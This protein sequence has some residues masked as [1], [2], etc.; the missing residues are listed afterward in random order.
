[1]HLKFQTKL[2]L[3]ILFL[4]LLTSGWLT[5]QN[6][7]EVEKMFKQEMKEEGFLLAR[8]VEN[9]IANSKVFE[10]QVDQLMAER[11]L[12]ASEAVNLLPIETMTNEQL[13][14]LAPKLNISGGIFVIGPDRKIAYSDVVDYVGWEYPAGH[15]MDP[16]F[17]GTSRTYM[18][19]IRGDL[20]SGEMVKYGGIALSTPGYSVQIGVEATVI[21]DIKRKFSPDVLLKQL[22][23]RD[24]VVYAMMINSDGI[25]IAGTEEMKKEE[26][27]DDAVTIDA[28]KNEKEGAAESINSDT[29]ARIY[30][31]QIPY[32]EDG[33]HKGSIAVGISLDRMEKTLNA[34]LIKSLI[35]TSITCIVAVLIGIFV[36]RHLVSPLKKLSSQLNDIAQGDFTI[37]Q[38]SRLLE[39]KD[40]LGLIANAVQKMRIELSQLIMNLKND[41]HSLEDGADLL[42]NIMSE[43]SRAIEENA[44]AVEALAISA[45]DQASESEKVLL[46]AE[47]LG[48][49]VDQGKKN[50][51]EANNRVGIVNNLS[52]NGESIITELA[53][54]TKKSIGRTDAV[55]N[56]I[57]NV[58]KTVRNMREFTGRIRSI[59]EQTNLLAL[60]ASIEAARAGEAGRGFSVVADEIRKLAE[61]TNQ[62][63]EQVEVI[64]AEITDQ[65]NAA[66]EDIEA[67]SHVTTQQRETL[68]QTLDIFERIQVSIIELVHSMNQVVDVTNAV[69]VSKDTILSAVNVLTDLTENL[70]ATC[71]Q[72]SASTEEQTAA[73]NEVNQLTDTNRSLASDLT[74]RVRR[75]KTIDS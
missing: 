34:H 41:A 17:D 16:I 1:M 61:E 54:V 14:E 26:A 19:E 75:F 27:Y 8:S 7:N 53:E 12:Q 67:I 36:I 40:E 69:G 74:E 62:T 25:A 64:I 35:A 56:G 3:M 51:E 13:I 65:T 5:Y 44:K 30:D 55:S 60:N 58:E 22:V 18:E 2:V 59:S 42:S 11:I 9:E 6:L 4:I 70:S 66:V 50:I 68:Q 38:D 37:E 48:D 49:K 47:E 24:D 63:T 23:E 21:L 20:I 43:T 33:M 10:K 39:Q 15:P 57:Q 52:S 28:I 71:E 72:I 46:S 45:S 32:Y 31:V 29:G 73:V